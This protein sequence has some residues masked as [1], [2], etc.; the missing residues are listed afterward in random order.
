GP[1]RSTR[2]GGRRHGASAR[3]GRR[4]GVSGTA[5]GRAGRAPG[6]LR[7]VVGGR[8]RPATR[9]VRGAAGAE[10][11]VRRLGRRRRGFDR[12]RGAAGA[13]RAEAQPQGRAVGHVRAAFGAADGVGRCAARQGAG[14]R[15]RRGGGGSAHRRFLER[16]GGAPVRS[17]WIRDLRRG[18][19]GAEGGGAL[20]RRDADGAAVRHP[21]SCGR[22][23]AGQGV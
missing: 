16:G 10:R 7:G 21:G 17:R 15:A 1:V 20:P 9:L 12:G 19:P 22:P 5:L 11:V 8:G 18:A 6:S 4:R 3:R 14:A 23:A 2:P 13:R